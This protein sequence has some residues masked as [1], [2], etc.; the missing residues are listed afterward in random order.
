MRTVPRNFRSVGEGAGWTCEEGQIVGLRIVEH[1]FCCED[2]VMVSPTS[3]NTRS[4]G[5]L[6]PSWQT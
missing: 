4:R 2:E 3:S 5:L 6:L 1:M